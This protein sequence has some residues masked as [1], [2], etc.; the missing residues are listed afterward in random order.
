MIGFPFIFRFTAV[1]VS[2]LHGSLLDAGLACHLS[3]STAVTARCFMENQS[4]LDIVHAAQQRAR[5]AHLSAMVFRDLALPVSSVDCHSPPI[6]SAS[7]ATMQDIDGGR[8]SLSFVLAHRCICLDL[9]F[10]FADV[11]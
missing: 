7:T 11:S 2:H 6:Y 3:L 4:R 10:A 9:S 8:P 5:D 1:T